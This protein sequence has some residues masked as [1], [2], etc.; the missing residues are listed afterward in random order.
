MRQTGIMIQCL[1][2]S[3]LVLQSVMDWHRTG[4]NWQNAEHRTSLA[5]VT[6]QSIT[7]PT[8]VRLISPLISRSTPEP[9]QQPGAPTAAQSLPGKPTSQTRPRRW[10]CLVQGGRLERVGGVYLGFVLL[11]SFTCNSRETCNKQITIIEKGL[12]PGPIV[13]P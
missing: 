2:R 6:R 8:M 4:C 7:I 5:C 13:M 3:G 11:P 12:Q 1:Y 10:L 9:P